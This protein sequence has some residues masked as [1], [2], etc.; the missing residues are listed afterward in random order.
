MIERLYCPRGAES[1]LRVLKWLVLAVLGLALVAGGAAFVWLQRPLPLALRG[2]PALDVVVPPGA[3]ARNVARALHQAGVQLPEGWLYG[4]FRLSG[5]ARDIKAGTYELTEGITPTELLGKLVRGEQAV[6]RVTLVEGWNYRQVLQA[7]KTAEH[8]RD[9][10]PASKDPAALMQA[11]GLQAS[12]PEGR[13]FPDTYVYPKRSNASDVLK[14]AAAAMD[15]QLA[16]AWAQRAPGS[17]LRSPAEALVLAS[18]V[19]KETGHAADRTQIAA[20]FNNRLRI[21]MRLQTDPTVIYGLGER[22][23]GNLRRRDLEADTPYNTYTRAG[24]PPTPIAMPGAASLLAAVQPAPSAALYFVA[25][26]D[27]TS[28]FSQ[29]LDEHNQAVRRYILKR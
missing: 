12:H 20:V 5:Q 26:G 4:W 21:G 27:G 25:K 22:F 23:D 6:R 14:Q 29:S 8:L 18:I 3:S 9:D 28:Q 11:L 19:E 17:A 13:F 16:R 10:L 7:L 1:V 15:T 2:E 24:L